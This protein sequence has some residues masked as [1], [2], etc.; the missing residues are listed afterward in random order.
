M[1]K[2]EQVEMFKSSAERPAN[3]KRCKCGRVLYHYEK[4]TCLHCLQAAHKAFWN[5]PVRAT[6]PQRAAEED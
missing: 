3:G 1:Q 6:Q 2:A 4:V 5:Q